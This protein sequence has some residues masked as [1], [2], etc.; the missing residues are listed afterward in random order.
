LRR[1]PL[2][3]LGDRVTSYEDWVQSDQ[4]ERI[5]VAVRL[6]RE[7]E[8]DGDIPLARNYLAIALLHSRK[9]VKK[10]R[11]EETLRLLSDSYKRFGDFSAK[12]G[13]TRAAKAAYRKAEVI[14]RKLEAGKY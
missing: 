9:L 12:E 7:A 13:K 6:A 11:N 5:D 1:N 8:S 14:I 10:V 2:F 3:G 4:E